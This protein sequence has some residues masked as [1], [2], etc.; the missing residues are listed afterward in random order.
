MLGWAAETRAR[1]GNLVAYRSTSTLKGCCA[2]QVKPRFYIAMQ[3]MFH[4][5][6]TESA[7]DCGGNTRRYFRGTVEVRCMFRANAIAQLEH[8]S[9]GM[10]H[11]AASPRGEMRVRGE[12]GL[13]D[14]RESGVAMHGGC[15]PSSNGLC[16]FAAGKLRFPRLSPS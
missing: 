2:C 4:G 11:V 14:S 6:C 16:R 3:V 8:A 5:T 12:A 1:S 13:W 10:G 15:A 9:V 7:I